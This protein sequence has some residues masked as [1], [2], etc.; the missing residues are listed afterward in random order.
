MLVEIKTLMTYTTI[1]PPISYFISEGLSM[2][3]CVDG[4]V[5]NSLELFISYL[6]VI[7]Q[8]VSAAG[9]SLASGAHSCF[10]FPFEN[11]EFHKQPKHP[12]GHNLST[13][14]LPLADNN[15]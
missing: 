14:P 6:Q 2:F 7:I 10:L 1:A 13:V 12:P 11:F 15:K 9:S 8:Y 3:L 4:C 5:L